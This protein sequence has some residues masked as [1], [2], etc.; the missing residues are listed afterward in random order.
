[1][2]ATAP[3]LPLRHAR[4]R[5]RC[6]LL[7]ML[8]A[9]GACDAEEER[10]STPGPDPSVGRELVVAIADSVSVLFPWLAVRAAGGTTVWLNGEVEQLPLVLD[11]AGEL[12]GSVGRLGDGPGEFRLARSAYLKGDSLVLA[13]SGREG[14]DLFDPTFAFVRRIPMPIRGI[15]QMLLLRG[16]T[17]IVPF[18]LNDVRSY[19]LPFHVVSPTGQILRSFGA[20]DRTVTPDFALRRL[21]VVAPHSDSAF[22][23]ARYDS[24]RIE[25]W[26]IDGKLVTTLVP[27]LKWYVPLDHDPAAWDIEPPPT[28]LI[29]FAWDGGDRL[30]CLFQRPVATWQ[31]NP[32]RRDATTDGEPEGP[33]LPMASYPQYAE[34]LIVVLDATTG[35]VISEHTLPHGSILA[36][37]MGPDLLFGVRPDPDGVLRPVVLQLSDDHLQ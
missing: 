10:A 13:V 8:L 1:M 20:V 5:V 29:A 7:A 36:G 19:G 31:A 4:V 28:T 18:P 12:K 30:T 24:L 16:D 27:D 25:L 23:A 21:R 14:L 34:Q 2:H 33:R 15:S 6:I 26:G 17:M 35:S 3:P 11:S 9:I 22:W 37:F 32:A